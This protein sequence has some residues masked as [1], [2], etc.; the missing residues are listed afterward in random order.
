MLC[1]GTLKSGS[2]C[3][4]KAKYDGYCGVHVLAGLSSDH[5]HTRS[6]FRAT[7]RSYLRATA[8]TSNIGVRIEDLP[9][10]VILN[11]LNFLDE[12]SVISFAK[13]I[14]MQKL[15]SSAIYMIF[16]KLSFDGIIHLAKTNNFVELM[17]ATY[18]R[19]SE[20]LEIFRASGRRPFH[21]FTGNKFRYSPIRPEFYDE[22]E[23]Q[24]SRLKA[25]VELILLLRGYVRRYVY[26]Y[27]TFYMD[28]GRQISIK[29]SATFPFTVTV[30]NAITYTYNFKYT[31]LE[32]YNCLAF[33]DLVQVFRCI[34]S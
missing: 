4:F 29:S 3:R 24:K 5:S 1:K 10:D 25:T 15:P 20:Q 14:W 16:K 8:N 26:K 17:A 31:N 30:T 34:L 27:N 23:V 21:N 9:A 22:R 12:K 6:Y 13:A 19:K 11:V 2:P 28:D 32:V 18:L 33:S 7:A